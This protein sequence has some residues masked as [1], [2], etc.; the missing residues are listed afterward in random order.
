MELAI[1]VNATLQV[2]RYAL[3]IDRPDLEPLEFHKFVHMSATAYPIKSNERIR[4]TLSEYPIDANLFWV[5][6]NPT[7]PH[8]EAW[9]YFVECD[10]A[11]H[12]IYRMPP[13]RWEN[14]GIDIMTSSQWFIASRDFVRY[15]AEAKPGTF[16]HEYSQYVEHIIVADEQFF[17]TILRHTEFCHKHHNTNFLFL[18]F[19]EWENFMHN[20]TN[21]RDARKCLMPDSERCGRSPKTITK[22]RILGLDIEQIGDLFGRKVRWNWA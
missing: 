11:V 10:D 21:A 2:M 18:E 22:E 6:E 7:S 20:D 3:A 15:L 1:V 19:G 5:L 9:H 13:K 8:E 4:Q 17:G 12:R 16:V 14:S